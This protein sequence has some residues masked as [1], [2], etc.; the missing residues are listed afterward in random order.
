MDTDFLVCRQSRRFERLS[1]GVGVNDALAQFELGRFVRRERV[2]DQ[3]GA[4]RVLFNSTGGFSSGLRIGTA[5]GW[6]RVNER[7]EGQKNDSTKRNCPRCE[8]H[9]H[10]T[11]DVFD[12]THSGSVSHAETASDVKFE[13]R[14]DQT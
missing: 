7:A 4:G 8:P 1:I 2:Q 6:L 5:A 3:N 12:H 10:W 14:I 11:G 9:G 13:W